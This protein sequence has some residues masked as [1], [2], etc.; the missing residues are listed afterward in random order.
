MLARLFHTPLVPHPPNQQRF[1]EAQGIE[2]H[3]GS[4]ESSGEHAPNAGCQPKPGSAVH[5]VA[6]QLF[7]ERVVAE[8]FSPEGLGPTN[9]EHGG[10]RKLHSGN[11]ERSPRGRSGMDPCCSRR[12]KCLASDMAAERQGRMRSRPLVTTEWLPDP[13]RSAEGSAVTKELPER[14]EKKTFPP[15]MESAVQRSRGRPSLPHEKMTR[16]WASRVETLE[17]ELGARVPLRQPTKL[18]SRGNRPHSAHRWAPSRASVEAP[19]RYA[20]PSRDLARRE[21]RMS[22]ADNPARQLVAQMRK[23]RADRP[24]AARLR[25]CSLPEGPSRPAAL[26]KTH[27][28]AA[29]ALPDREVLPPRA[30]HSPPS[31][32]LLLAREA[33]S[34]SRPRRDHLYSWYWSTFT[35]SSTPMA[36]SV[37]TAIEQ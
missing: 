19:G 9:P 30:T 37:R 10:K 23:A 34:A 8:H 35:F 21:T 27:S 32:P 6:T 36:S 7:R 25:A 20:E 14:Q 12:P 24:H 1:P 28:R 5:S 13:T 15:E 17:L 11:W 18:Q 3:W 26:R 29:P 33:L 2:R 31:A 4:R 22:P 16:G